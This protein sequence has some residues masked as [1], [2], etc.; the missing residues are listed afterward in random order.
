[1]NELKKLNFKLNDINYLISISS[2][3]TTD[4]YHLQ[5]YVV[6]KELDSDRIIFHTTCGDWKS[7]KSVV[8]SYF[9][10]IS[11]ILNIDLNTVERARDGFFKD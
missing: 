1:M 8:N 6:L 5:F 3:L 2:G 11:E 4:G 9:I 7:V 10:K